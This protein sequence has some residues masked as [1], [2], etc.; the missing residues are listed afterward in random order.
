MS[1]RVEEKIRA[2]DVRT[3]LCGLEA[4]TCFEGELYFRDEELPRYRGLFLYATTGLVVLKAT[5][6]EPRGLPIEPGDG[7]EC[8]EPS[9]WSF[10]GHLVNIII[11]VED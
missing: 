9:R 5:P 11:R 10:V 2:E 7:W 4:G 3:D 1:I 8:E 6:L